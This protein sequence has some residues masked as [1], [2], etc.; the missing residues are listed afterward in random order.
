[1]A[2]AADF[3]LNL[4]SILRMIPMADVTELHTPLLDLQLQMLVWLLVVC[5]ELVFKKHK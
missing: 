5:P 3:T 2:C 4:A 1:V